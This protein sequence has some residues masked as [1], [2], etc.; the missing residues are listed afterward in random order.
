MGFVPETWLCGQFFFFIDLFLF[1]IVVKDTPSRHKRVP[2]NLS[3][4]LL[5]F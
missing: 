5:S 1:L 2:L 4:V 3:I